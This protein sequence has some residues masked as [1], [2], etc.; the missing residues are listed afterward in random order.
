MLCEFCKALASE[1]STLT[2][3]AS[4]NSGACRRTEAVGRRGDVQLVVKVRNRVEQCN[5]FAPY[6]AAENL[7]VTHASAE[8][9][10]CAVR[11]SATRPD[12]TRRF[13]LVHGN[14]ANLTTWVHTVDALRE[15][16]DVL[17][18]DS[19]GFGRSPALPASSMTLDGYA[20]IVMQLA[21]H[22]AWRRLDLV[23]HSHGAMVIQ[24]A[25][26]R[27]PE[28]VRSLVLLGT[29]GVPTHLSY[30]LL[31][32]P[33]AELVL[34]EHV[35]GRLCS[36]TRL[37]PLLEAVVRQSAR[38]IFAPDP[39]PEGYAES[40]AAELVHSPEILLSMAQ[41]TRDHPC[42]RLATQAHDIVA[43]TLFIHGENDRLVPVAYAR[44]LRA[45]LTR[46]E[47]LEFVSLPGGHMLHMT[48]PERLN[49]RMTEWL[50][51]N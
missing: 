8:R 13:V 2:S 50:L 6:D 11:F 7:S 30:R 34:G 45:L 23:G 1:P 49:R 17:L 26:A 9:P 51:R 19:P 40:E 38:G 10:V 44:R 33:G 29:G 5:M 46:A 22:F 15:L 27:F 21:D 28:R 18:F 14:P 37:R 16:G 43:P 39:V 4:P 25:A 32:L 31:S 42:V 47:S 3:P 12:A 20:D 24:T 35:A 41:I 48:Q 36:S